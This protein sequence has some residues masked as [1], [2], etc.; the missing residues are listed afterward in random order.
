MHCVDLGESF[1]TSI[2]LQKSAS[3]QPRTSPSKFGRKYSILFNRVLTLDERN[4]Q[5]VSEALQLTKAVVE[6]TTMLQEQSR[7][8]LSLLRDIPHSNDEMQDVVDGFEAR[9]RSFQTAQDS[10]QEPA[11]RK[12][13]AASTRKTRSERTV[14]QESAALPTNSRRTLAQRITKSKAVQELM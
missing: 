11:R 4:S 1:P 3:I 9:R 7:R 6:H 14:D 8:L 10:A 13:K 12:V 2:Y 5:V